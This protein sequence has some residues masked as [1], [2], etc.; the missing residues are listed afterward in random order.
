[1][2]GWKDRK[3]G[4]EQ[5]DG[6][7]DACMVECVEGQADGC[8]DGWMDQSLVARVAPRGAWPYVAPFSAFLRAICVELPA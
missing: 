5:T 7:M 6:Q 1:M 3:M 2:S 4:R 8:L